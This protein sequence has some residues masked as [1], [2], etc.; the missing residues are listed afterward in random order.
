MLYDGLHDHKNHW[1][2]SIGIIYMYMYELL[3]KR[4]ATY[5]QS[6]ILL[7]SFCAIIIGN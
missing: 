3:C 5:V 4:M 7:E 2:L 6:C 1:D